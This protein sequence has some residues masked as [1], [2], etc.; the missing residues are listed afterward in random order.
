MSAKG[1]I[2][3]HTDRKTIGPF[4]A[5]VSI[6]RRNTLIFEE[7]MECWNGLQTSNI[8]YERTEV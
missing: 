7:K 3:E 8:F 5:V 1:R 2:T 4:G 6:D